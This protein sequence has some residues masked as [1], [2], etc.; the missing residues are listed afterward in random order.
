MANIRSLIK[1]ETMNT[2]KVLGLDLGTNSIGWALIEENEENGKIIGLGSRIVPMDATM[3]I[4]FSKGRP[5]S[6]NVIRRQ[7]RSARR[8]LQRYKLRRARLYK[9]LQILGWLPN[10]ESLEEL[11][12]YLSGSQEKKEADNTSFDLYE[13]RDRALR[14][15]ISEAELARILIHL[16]QRRG[17]L[18]NRKVKEEEE[19]VEHAKQSEEEDSEEESGS[20]KTYEKVLVS[21]VD[22]DNSGKKRIYNIQLSDGRVG[23]SYQSISFERDKPIELLITEKKSKKWG[24]SFFFQLPQKRDWNYRKHHINK[25][26]E[27]SKLTVGQFYYSML[28]SDPHF[29]TKDNIILREKYIAEFD[30]IWDAQLNFRKGSDDL[31]I[32]NSKLRDIAQSLY[33]NNIERQNVLAKKGLRYILRD[34]ILYYQR[35]LKSQK[36]SIA[37]CR[38]ENEKR[39]IPISHPLYQEFRILDK[40]NNIRVY[41]MRD[42][43]CTSQ[44][45]TEEI[46]CAIIRK[47][48]EQKSVTPKVIKSLLIPKS[49]DSEFYLSERDEKRPLKGNETKVDIW[50]A[51]AGD[52][53]QEEIVNN[54]A[55]LEMVWHILYS[56]DK[57]EDVIHALTRPKNGLDLSEASARKLSFLSYSSTYGSLSARAIKRILPLMRSGSDW[58]LDFINKYNGVKERI[59]KLLNGEVDDSMDNRIREYAK[60]VGLKSENDLKGLPYWAAVYI[61]YGSHSNATNQKRWLSPDEIQ[62][63]PKNALRNPIVQQIVNESL[64]VVKEIWRKYGEIDE[65]RIE[66]ARDLK[67]NAKE[68][69]SIQQAQNQNRTL[70][71]GIRNRLMEM[72]RPIN[73]ADKYRL[74]IESLDKE[75]IEKKE[76]DNYLNYLLPSSN[77]K[78]TSNDIVKYKLWEEQAHL[79]PYTGRPIPLSALFSQDYQI[80]HIIPRQRFYDDSFSNKVVVESFIN[81]DKGTPGRNCTA[82][83]YISGGPATTGVQILNEDDYFSLVNRVFKGQKRKKLLMKEIPS[84]FVDRQKKDTQYITRAVREELARIVGMENVHTTTGGI[85]DHLREQWGIAHLFK[86]ILLPRFEQLEMKLAGTKDE[87]SLINRVY[88]NH[89]KKDILKV[90]GYSKRLDHRHHAAD[91]LVIA[92]TKPSHI[93]RLNDL[94]KIY[95][96]R[97]K[98]AREAIQNEINVKRR[99]GSWS[100]DKPWETFIEDAK[101]HL[102]TCIVSIK[103]RNRLLTKGVN[104]YTRVNPSTGAKEIVEQ[105]NGKMLSVRG[106]LHNPQVFGETK[107]LEKVSIDALL[108]ILDSWKKTNSSLEG[109]YSKFAHSWQQNIIQELIEN[110]GSDLKKVRAAL[111]N[112]LPTMNGREVR[113]YSIFRTRYVKRTS[114]SALTESKVSSIANQQLREEIKSHIANFGGGDL[115]KAFNADG[116]MV[117]NQSRKV[118][119]NAVKVI[120]GDNQEVGESLGKQKL[121]RKNSFNSKLHI[122]TAGNFAFAIYENEEDIKNGVWPTRREYD[123]VSFYDAVQLKLSGESI[124]QQRQGMKL[125]VLSANDLVYVPLLGEGPNSID[126][127]DLEA[128]SRRLFT[129]T[130]ASGNEIYFTPVTYADMIIQGK[131]LGSQNCIQVFEGIGIKQ[132]CIKININRIGE[133]SI[134]DL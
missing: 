23:A 93:K 62:L 30:A 85:T 61:V 112:G 15:I 39:V 5:I 4:D 22:I 27:E 124:F 129:M 68:R 125:T 51:L 84:D 65:I 79:S 2:K 122:N 60:E 91:A 55:K 97:K 38:Y 46:R 100:F 32:S 86:E 13:L 17:F 48:N 18:S 82:W 134:V 92:C 26:I 8:L 105:K 54:P 127:N 19:K 123:I 74:W 63:L 14:E 94:N 98:Q 106:Q 107:I 120:E 132:V 77:W 119:V 81:K 108:K 102:E 57:T 69:E 20:V 126:W 31:L 49:Q 59:D 43:D 52:S 75:S 103:N 70:N 42:D 72:G 25:L 111:K 44:F 89:L 66:L 29:R 130:K 114:L 115:K 99:G 131:E 117:F 16:N 67:N 128:V 33:P 95:Q 36:Q 104:K 10:F 64:Q 116:M 24:K 109:F 88:D 76:I 28:K 35:P 73:D 80:D 110:N 47:L 78:P 40:V 87:V 45:M 37:L 34:D 3:L 53:K 133:L 101:R 41:N 58:S 7:A 56:L 118:P 90:Q 1:I 11:Q 121:I 71:D 9:V 113:E 21:S 6:K 50:N 96:S 12:K 83:E